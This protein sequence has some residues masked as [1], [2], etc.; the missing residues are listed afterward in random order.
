MDGKGVIE[1]MEIEKRMAKY[2]AE[3]YLLSK[4]M[5]GSTSRTVF[6]SYHWSAEC[7]IKPDVALTSYVVLGRFVGPLEA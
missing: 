5:E 3:D 1:L 2:K 6:L 7:N 4:D